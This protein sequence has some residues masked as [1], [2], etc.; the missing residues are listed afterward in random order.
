MKPHFNVVGSID[1]DSLNKKKVEPIKEV[2]VS[3]KRRK[4]IKQLSPPM[5]RKLFPPNLQ[6]NLKSNRISLK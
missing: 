6:L 5:S 4:L 3:E 1:L 2:P